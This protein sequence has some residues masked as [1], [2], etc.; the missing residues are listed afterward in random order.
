MGLVKTSIALALYRITNSKVIKGYLWF[1]IG[2]SIA[3]S[4]VI[5]GVLLSI[6]SPFAGLWDYTITRSCAATAGQRINGV[7]IFSTISAIVTD[8]SCAIIPYII[9]WRLQM[10]KKT[11]IL[12][13][14]VLG[15]SLV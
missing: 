8:F 10:P 9:I 15:L 2:L 1:I 12:L 3:T 6:C 13:A 14:S 11:K 7:F 5:L 4:F